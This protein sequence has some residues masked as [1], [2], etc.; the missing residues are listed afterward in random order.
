MNLRYVM[1]YTPESI[2][3]GKWQNNDQIKIM[4]AR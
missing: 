1:V 3:S 2:I 4:E